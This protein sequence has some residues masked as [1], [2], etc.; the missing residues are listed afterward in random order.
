MRYRATLGLLVCLLLATAGALAYF[1]LYRATKVPLVV[2]SAGTYRAQLPPNGWAAEDQRKLTL[3]NSSNIKSHAVAAGELTRELFLTELDRT[4]GEAQPGGPPRQR[5]VILYVSAHGA[6]DEKNEPCLL[7]ADAD[8]LDSA[9]WLPVRTLLERVQDHAELKK[10]GRSRKLVLLDA[11]RLPA[12]WRLGQ[13]HNAFN[14]RLEALVVELNRSQGEGEICVLNSA[15]DG[16]RGWD[17][18]ELGGSAFGHFVAQALSGAADKDGD[19][20][21]SLAE[22]HGYLKSAVRQ[23]VRSR[24]GDRQEPRLM[25]ADADF[26]LVHVRGSKVDA[27]TS[28]A[29]GEQGFDPG[30]AVARTAKLWQAREELLE[31]GLV[32]RQP[33]LAAELETKLLRLDALLVAG[34]GYRDEARQ[35]EDELGKLLS[36]ARRSPWPNKMASLSVRSAEFWDDPEFPARPDAELFVRW[37]EAK[38]KPPAAGEPPPPVPAPPAAIASV[39]RW[40][41]ERAAAKAP[42]DWKDVDDGIAFLDAA[43]PRQPEFLEAAWLRLC[44]RYVNRERVPASA[45]CGALSARDAAEAAATPPDERTQYWLQTSVDRADQARRRADDLLLVGTAPALVDAATAWTQVTS[46]QATDSYVRSTALQTTIANAYRLRDEAWSKLPYLAEWSIATLQPGAAQSGKLEQSISLDRLRQTI[47]ALQSLDEALEQALV[48]RQWNEALD[49]R[50]GEF[51]SRFNELK[52]AYADHCEFLRRTGSDERA[53]RQIHEALR[54]PLLSADQRQQLAQIAAKIIRSRAGDAPAAADDDIIVSDDES[55]NWLRRLVRSRLAPTLLDATRLDVASTSEASKGESK[56]SDTSK[57]ET[58]GGVAAAGDSGTST[59]E[60]SAAAETDEADAA[61]L[62]RGRVLELLAVQGGRVRA[63]LAQARPT[64]S[65]WIAETDRGAEEP[66]VRLRWFDGRQLALWHAARALD[67]FWGDVSGASS[68]A[69][70]A[71]EP[72][73]GAA[74]STTPGVSPNDF[75]GAVEPFFATWADGCL[76]AAADLAP[77]AVASPRRGGVDLRQLLDA[78]RQ[79]AKTGPVIRATELTIGEEDASASNVVSVESKTEIPAGSLTLTINPYGDRQRSLALIDEQKQDVTRRGVKIGDES[80][81]STSLPYTLERKTLGNLPTLEAVALYRGHIWHRPIPVGRAGRGEE[82]VVV[83]QPPIA[84]RVEV[85]GDN[86]DDVW[87][88]FVLDVSGS[89]N[90]PLGGEAQGVRRWNAALNAYFELLDELARMPRQK[91]RVGL[92]L[93]GHRTGWSLVKNQLQLRVNPNLLAAGVNP[94]KLPPPALDVEALTPISD[95]QLL[96]RGW[97]EATRRKLETDYRPWAQT[98]L[99][100]SVQE[101]LGHFDREI[102]RGGIRATAPRHLIVITDG[103]NDPGPKAPDSALVRVSSLETKLRSLQGQGKGVQLDLIGFD[104][105]KEIEKNKTDVEELRNLAAGSGGRFHDARN[106]ESLKKALEESLNI[107]RFYVRA[108]D[109]ELPPVEQQKRLGD[110][111]TIAPWTPLDRLASN[112]R[113]LKFLVGVNGV[114]RATMPVTVSGGEALELIYNRREQRLEFT[115]FKSSEFRNRR[116]PVADPSSATLNY[117]VQPHLPKREGQGVTFPVS[118]QNLDLRAFTPRPAL[119]WAEITP[120]FATPPQRTPKFVFQELEFE[121][122]QPVPVLQ[123]RVARWPAEAQQAQLQMW[124]K[125]Q[126]DVEPQKVVAFPPGTPP[127]KIELDGVTVAVETKLRTATDPFFRVL[128]TQQYAEGTPLPGYHVDLRPTASAVS[129]RT[130]IDTRTV[131]HEFRYD[132]PLEGGDSQLQLRFLSRDRIQRNA[133][134]VARQP[135]GKIEP[136]LITLPRNN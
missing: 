84:P 94:D 70:G 39:W 96:N 98:P 30:V 92:T 4:L 117:G 76:R 105:S 100:F 127:G 38:A 16:E 89:M 136:L 85:R 49:K 74:A 54:V 18:P 26:P 135:D 57:S 97:I 59:R 77:Q 37:R 86:A 90:E 71:N 15:G 58:S 24:R 40:L 87:V 31:R 11:A 2:L 88:I 28:K 42:L 72:A 130:S 51:E 120:V 75:G 108:G 78:R 129:C 122:S 124:F 107:G 121:P 14:E 62:S 10:R 93:Y 35:L 55:T 41:Q 114:Q 65:R 99:F 69:G 109:A 111:W 17:A 91:Y 113:G 5:N 118:L 80:Q 44:A 6:V 133:V 50:V 27:V 83:R 36:A 19:A 1:I 67:D 102:D 82:T 104:M 23:W 132:R 45:L 103:L 81:E 63:A 29:A 110:V 32:R 126:D 61:T 52:A 101:M 33:L 56:Q 68:L 64:S 46:P 60:S 106:L 125:M 116:S 12:L 3:V 34:E 112:D 134:E 25:P 119:V 20:A 9:T 43:G 115:E 47:D 22:L 21:V 53:W 95:H 7:F 79:L 131:R 73:P 13:I 8:P 66:A 128:V 48:A 123:F